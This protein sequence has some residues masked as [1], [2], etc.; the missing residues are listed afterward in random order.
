MN[1]L[2]LRIV[3]NVNPIFKVQK[4]LLDAEIE[5]FTKQHDGGPEIQLIQ[6]KV[7]LNNIRKSLLRYSLQVNS[8]K[9]EAARVGILPTSRAPRGRGK[10]ARGRGR[11]GVLARGGGRG[12]GGA[13][14][15]R[16][17]AAVK[18][19]ENMQ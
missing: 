13:L 14:R 19:G 6:Q 10:L 9:I 18:R 12:G 15:G 7:F 4:D 16:G 5:L 2:T 8:L 1:R 3:L 11:G 17:G